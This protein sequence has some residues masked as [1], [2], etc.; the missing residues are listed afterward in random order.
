MIG[1][2]RSAEVEAEEIESVE[3]NNTLNEFISFLRDIVIILLIV[4]FI[5][6][7]IITPFRIN[8][9]SMENS[10]HDKEYILVDKLSYLDMRYIFYTPRGNGG[11]DDTIGKI[12][13]S[14]LAKIPFKVGEPKR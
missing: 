3:A 13:Q 8:G 9:S 10:Y 1:S 4:L 12:F 14:T 7:V 6:W 11:I 2:P 5:R